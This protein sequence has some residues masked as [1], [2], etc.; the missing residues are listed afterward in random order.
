LVVEIGATEG[1]PEGDIEPNG[2]VIT[3]ESFVELKMPTTGVEK[4][5]ENPDAIDRPLAPCSGRG[6]VAKPV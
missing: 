1:R 2:A 3:I 4:T 6:L 5:V